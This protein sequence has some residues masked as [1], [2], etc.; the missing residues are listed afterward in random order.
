M[1][2]NPCGPIVNTA[3]SSVQVASGRK[4]ERWLI[5][6]LKEGDKMIYDNVISSQT[7]S[8]YNRYVIDDFGVRDPFDPRPPS[9]TRQVRYDRTIIRGVSWKDDV[10]VNPDSAGKPMAGKTISIT[11]PLDADQSGKTYIKPQEF[12]ALPQDNN[13]HWTLNEGIADPDIIILGEGPELNALYDID[14]LRNDFKHTSIAQ[15]S[16]NT[17]VDILPHW[18]VRG[19]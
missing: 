16:D 9:A 17:G 19:V 14:S 11:I 10:S 4:Q 5:A 2:D 13:N 8:V 7:I 3:R 18:A 6:L 12:A 1:Q 15:V